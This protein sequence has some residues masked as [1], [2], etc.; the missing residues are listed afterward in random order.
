VA[1]IL[2]VEDEQLVAKDIELSLAGMGHTV[3]GVASSSEDALRMA[4]ARRPDLV[5]MDVRIEGDL[6]GIQTAEILRERHDVALVYVTAHADA[7]TVARAKRTQPSGYLLKPFR[8]SELRGAVEI[9]LYKS[10]AERRL[11]ERERWFSTTL[12]AIGDAV[13]TVD[14]LGHVTFMNPVAESMLGI[15]EVSAQ[16]GALTDLLHVFSARTGDALHDPAA[17]ALQGRCLVRLPPD[18]VL[19][20]AVGEFAVRA[21][22]SPI[23][24]D[25]GT[26]LGAVVVFQDV[27]EQSRLHMQI[28]AADRF[29]SL[30]MLAASVAHDINNPLAYIVSNSEVLR[31]GLGEIERGLAELREPRAREARARARD[32][33]EPLAELRQGAERIR[34]IAADLRVF[35]A[36]RDRHWK[37]I[38]VCESV[39]WALRIT[40]NQIRHR[41][42]LIR[43]LQPVPRV[44]AS[45]TQLGQVF[46]GLLVNACQSIPEGAVESHEIRVATRSEENR[47]IVTVSDTGPGIAAQHMHRIFEPFSASSSSEDSSGLGLSICESIL[48][49]F[50]GSIR[51]IREPGSGTTFEVTLPAATTPETTSAA[52]LAPPHAPRRG[53]ILVIDDEPLVVRTLIRLLSQDHDLTTFQD[54][55]QAVALLEQGAEF[56]LVLCDVMMPGFSG[57][58]FYA[59]TLQI[60]PTLASRIAFMTGGGFTPRSNEF[61]SSIPNPRVDKP[62]EREELLALVQSVLRD[63]T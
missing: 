39:E 47:V 60:A 46:V 6:D 49:S 59:R 53:R 3:I 14:P 61:L 5:L 26:A 63:D 22:A 11:K 19:A 10:E 18:S 38:D 34:R 33:R 21:A 51:A 31:D 58:D 45:E 29:A 52:P 57:M 17:A 1:H 50:G 13:V 16:G 42:K 2:V 44:E 43:A 37:R 8:E 24:A 4:R 28:A 41:A 32:L 7:G 12:R 36:E 25:D 9:A 27:S 54:A 40:A 56:D 15:A 35:A 48:R 55:R 20:T 23:L 62:F 30:G